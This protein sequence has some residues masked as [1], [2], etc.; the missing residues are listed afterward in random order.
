MSSIYDWS[1]LAASNANSDDNINWAE[2]QPPSS[3]NNSSRSMMQRIRE[4]LSDLGAVSQTTG[5]TNTIAFSSKSPFS[6]YVDGIRLTFRASN[7]NTGAATLNVNS[8]GSKPLFMIGT[9]GVSALSAG[10]ITA[11]GIYEVIYSTALDTGSGGWILL[12]PT[13]QYEPVGALK[14]MAAPIAP[15]G[16]LYCNGAA[17]SRTTYAAL[18]NYIGTRFGAGDNSTTFNLPD[19]RGDFIRG[20]DDGRGVDP[21]RV[22]GA[23]QLSQNLAHTHT[24]SGSTSV[25]GLHVHTFPNLRV[26]NPGAGYDFVNSSG[27]LN[28]IPMNISVN[29]AGAHSHTFSGSSSSSGGA[30]ARPVN[31]TGY[32]CIKY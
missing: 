18:F 13:V 8:I 23:R 29:A 16:F 5:T 22:F 21:G 24:V 32:I 14:I 3:V 9:T 4:L 31:N 10:N 25:D 12:N 27:S 11:N 26:G 30:E 7:T 15:Q 2:G 19:F 1:L 20:W 6:A 17:V 28:A